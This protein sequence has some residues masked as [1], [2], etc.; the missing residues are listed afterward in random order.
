MVPPKVGG[1]VNDEGNPTFFSN[2]TKGKNLG[3]KVV[4]IVQI[5]QIKVSKVP[6]ESRLSKVSKVQWDHADQN[7]QSVQM[8]ERFRVVL[9]ISMFVF[10]ILIP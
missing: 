8:V 10:E 4:Q 1:G 9:S 6:R 3:Q 7:D 5:V 2:S